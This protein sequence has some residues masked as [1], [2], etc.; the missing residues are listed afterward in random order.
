MAESFAQT[1]AKEYAKSMREQC[2]KRNLKKAAA[3][4]K[5]EPVGDTQARVYVPNSEAPNAYVFNY[6]LRHPLNY[7]N[8]VN[9]KHAKSSQRWFART[10][11]RN[12]LTA[13]QNDTAAA[14]RALE[15]GMNNVIE[16]DWNKD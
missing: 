10:P 6:G 16:N 13:T 7:P 2:L 14:E 15:A 5:S 9:A 12:F 1:A 8:Q 11:R 4:V 3:A